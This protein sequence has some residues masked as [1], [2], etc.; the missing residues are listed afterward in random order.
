MSSPI[1]PNSP[2]D[3]LRAFV[4][5]GPYC[6]AYWILDIYTLQ[7]VT[8]SLSLTVSKEPPYQIGNMCDEALHDEG[9]PWRLAKEYLEKRNTEGRKE[10]DE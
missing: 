6:D 2:D 10:S 3:I 1:D 7:C 4:E 8:C 9:C 5:K